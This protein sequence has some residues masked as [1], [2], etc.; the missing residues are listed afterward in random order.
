MSPTEI[1]TPA[2][3]P[4][5]TPMADDSQP[6]QIPET[7]LRS[8]IVVSLLGLLFASG[9]MLVYAVETHQADAAAMGATAEAPT[10]LTPEP[11]NQQR[12]LALAR[13]AMTAQVDTLRG[14]LDDAQRRIGELEQRIADAATE[15]HEVA[16]S[17]DGQIALPQ[18]RTE[19]AE[20]AL[21]AA[22]AEAT[23]R[24]DALDRLHADFAA[25]QARFTER[26][27][28]VTLGEAELRFAPG[29]ADLPAMPVQ[30]LERVAGV[31][32]RHP[33]LDV[34]LRG[35]TDS[36]GNAETNRA[37]SKQRAQ[38]VREALIGLGLDADRIRAEGVGA[39]EPVADNA[40]AAGRGRNRRVELYLTD[41]S[42]GT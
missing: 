16:A 24:Q 10:A 20:R 40:T 34:L 18:A 17:D 29:A 13:Q 2:P 8:T 21:A 7:R 41:L 4:A 15:G 28:L 5:A 31:L 35:H 6:A 12:S 33:E 3:L 36:Q 26:G 14:E 32:D 25:L 42:V 11:D 9:L 23:A 1:P 30:T 38:A 27:V 39:A 22:R 19:E 37:L